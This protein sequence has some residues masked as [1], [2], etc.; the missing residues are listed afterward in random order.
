MGIV[1]HGIVQNCEF[2]LT[3]RYQ[4][5]QFAINSYEQF[6][7]NASLGC[8]IFSERAVKYPTRIVRLR[9]TR[10]R[11]PRRS[12]S[13]RLDATP[14]C[15]A[16]DGSLLLTSFPLPSGTWYP[17]FAP[18]TFR[19]TRRSASCSLIIYSPGCGSLRRSAYRPSYSGKYWCQATWRS[20]K[21]SSLL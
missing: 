19:L 14:A 15:K 18:P 10:Y 17:L 13:W 1:E 4:T 9:C 16:G 3:H 12:W 21:P 8:A 2:L 5:L 7:P 20:G 6:L 11:L